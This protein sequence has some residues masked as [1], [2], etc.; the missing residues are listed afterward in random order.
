MFEVIV[1][2]NLL[3]TVVS[4]YLWFFFLLFQLIADNLSLKRLNEKLQK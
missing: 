1:A 2:T 3:N 4:P